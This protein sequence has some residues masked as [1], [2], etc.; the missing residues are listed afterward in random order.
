MEK[1]PTPELPYEEN[2]ESFAKWFRTN[3]KEKW[4]NYLSGN[5]KDISIEERDAM[6]AFLLEHGTKEEVESKLDSF[7]NMT[8]YE[9]LLS[10]IQS[11]RPDLKFE[12][13]E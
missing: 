6:R 7:N 10:D 1:S 4:D 5:E 11:K 13:T 3:A 12:E 2:N 8:A 9:T